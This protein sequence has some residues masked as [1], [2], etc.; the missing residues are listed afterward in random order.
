V[1]GFGL[2]FGLVLGCLLP[3]PV[4]ATNVVTY[5]YDNLRTGWNQTETALTPSTVAGGGFGLLAQVPLDEQVDAQPLFVAGQP[6]SGQGVHDVVYVATQNNSIYAI[7]ANSGA[8][9]L[10]QN[11]GAPVPIQALPI[12]CNNN[13]NNVGITSTPVI[14]AGTNTLYAMT[15]TTENNAAVYRLH[16]IDLTTLQD[17]V[18]SAVV[19]ASAAATN[20]ATLNFNAA[21]QRQRPA[22][23]ETA[24]NIYAGFG[25]F[26]DV[27]GG[28]SRGWVLGWNAGTLAP[29]PISKTINEVPKDPRNFF[30]SSIWMSGYGIASDDQGSLY[31]VTGN[32]DKF[33]DTYNP[34]SNVEESVVKVSTDLTTIQDFF[35]PT[36]T[37]D[38]WLNFDRSDWDFGAGGVL[39]LPDQPGGTPHLAVAAG[40]GGPLYLLSRDALGGSIK[41]NAALGH[42]TNWGCWCGQ[43]YF[44][45]ADGIG[46]VVQSNGWEVVV[47]T[48]A[49]KRKTELVQESVAAPF[50][51]QQQPGF[52]TTVSSNGTSPASAVIWAVTRTSAQNAD[53]LGLYLVALD[54]AQG[55]TTLFS[56]EAGTWPFAASSNSNIVPV[57]ANGHV[58]VAS[59]GNLSIFGLATP[60]RPKRAFHAPPPPARPALPGVAHQF[61]GVVVAMDATSITLR[62]RTGARAHVDVSAARNAGAT[63]PLAIGRP[64]EL[65]VNDGPRGTLVAKSALHLMGPPE[66]WPAD[67]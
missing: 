20:G 60:G 31:F 39:L 14:D 2:R 19:G 25:S 58:F 35:T 38:G 56:A 18:P 7:D 30:L 49:T 59:Y 62:L 65:R 8:V 46:R 24:G 64:A 17:Q 63:V 55:A 47:Y 23:I 44:T 11:F 26:C 67:Q 16:A 51:D 12:A 22:L 42:Y 43:T 52:F 34:V 3:V 50:N 54:P 28:T 15:Y 41:P 13:S 53:P 5:H 27:S 48:V 9:L 10:Q 57:S 32:S 36:G 40:K 21:T 29:L 37:E 33:G 4:G 66:I 61:H 6:I 1:A 45:G